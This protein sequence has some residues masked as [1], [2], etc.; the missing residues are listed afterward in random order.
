MN[1]KLFFDIGTL[2]FL[3]TTGQPK[4]NLFI[5][6]GGDRSPQLIETLIATAHLSAKDYIVVLPMAASEPDPSYY[7]K[8]QLEKACNNT[9]ANLNCAKSIY[10]FRPCHLYI[11]V[12][13]FRTV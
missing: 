3:T 9:I 13:R 11:Y 7:I 2:L 1:R 12:L 5:I 10:A 8:A 4:V 6:G